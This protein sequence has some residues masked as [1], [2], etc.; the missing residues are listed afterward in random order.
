MVLFLAYEDLNSCTV[1]SVHSV[2]CGAA[3]SPSLLHVI[4]ILQ[5]LH[6]QAPQG[7]AGDELTLTSPVG[8][9][10]HLSGPSERAVTLCRVEV[11]SPHY[12]ST[13]LHRLHVGAVQSLLWQ[14]CVFGQ[15]EVVRARRR[16]WR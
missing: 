10:G 3:T 16:R 6:R 13:L 11:G 4:V 9:A 2:L 14:G 12:T 5:S 1:H 7:E 15:L 8:A